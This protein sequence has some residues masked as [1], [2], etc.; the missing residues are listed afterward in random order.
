MR[1][2]VCALTISRDRQG[3]MGRDRDGDGIEGARRKER[4]EWN[5]VTY[6]E[7]RQQRPLPHGYQAAAAEAK[8]KRIYLHISPRTT[9]LDPPPPFF[10]GGNLGFRRFEGFTRSNKTAKVVSVGMIARRRAWWRGVP[11]VRGR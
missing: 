11:G 9:S 5:D 1:V 2:C 8:G 7:R 3:H 10:L 4:N 6:W